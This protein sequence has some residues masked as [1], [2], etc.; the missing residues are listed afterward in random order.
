MVGLL[1][2]LRLRRLMC[3]KAPPFRRS[4]PNF[5]GAA[6][7]VCGVAATELTMLAGRPQA[8]R[9][10]GGRAALDSLST[11]SRSAILPDMSSNLDQ[12]TADA[13]KLPLRDRVQLAQRLVSTI[14]DEEYFKALLQEQQK[15]RSEEK[16]EMMLTEGL[17][18]ES[19]ALNEKDWRHA[20]TE[21]E[22]RTNQNK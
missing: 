5:F 14:D 7:R 16:L 10:S 13:M 21:M 2:P 17:A 1:L 12:L 3:G 18:T 9:T 4:L 6:P 22:N 8:F 19:S 11:S 15:I 20:R